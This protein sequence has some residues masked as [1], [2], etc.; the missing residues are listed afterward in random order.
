MHQSLTGKAAELGVRIESR[1]EVALGLHAGRVRCA[2]GIQDR[3]G[4]K[5]RD[6]VIAQG[7][8]RITVVEVQRPIQVKSL[9]DIQL[10]ACQLVSTA[11]GN[12]HPVCRDH[13]TA[14]LERPS[15]PQV[16]QT[17]NSQNAAT[18][19]VSGGIIDPKIVTSPHINYP[20]SLRKRYSHHRV[21]KRHIIKNFQRTAVN[22]A[23]CVDRCTVRVNIP[24]TT[25]S[26]FDPTLTGRKTGPTQCPLNA[27]PI[28]TVNNR[29]IHHKTG[30]NHQLGPRDLVDLAIAAETPEKRRGEDA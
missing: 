7:H 28:R 21:T 15:S 4:G 23:I 27:N 8:H 18:E 6:G 29:V 17:I 30:R 16:Q 10:S 14:L 12:L 5:L 22:R 11:G 13:T 9:K 3:T 20:A 26:N 1:R 19:N 25:R 24:Q 2:A